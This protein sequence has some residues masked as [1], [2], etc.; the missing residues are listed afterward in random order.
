MSA[1]NLSECGGGQSSVTLF[2]AVSVAYTKTV[3]AWVEVN[4]TTATITLAGPADVWFGFGLNASE[5][6]A[7]PY[8]IIVDGQGNVTERVLAD[9]AA[10]TVLPPLL[11]VL[12]HTVNQG[13]RVLV[14]SRALAGLSA[15][16]F[17]FDS[18]A[19]NSE[20]PVISA[21]GSGPAFALVDRRIKG[22]KALLLLAVVVAG[23]WITCLTTSFDKC[24]CQRVLAWSARNVQRPVFAA[25]C[26]VTTVA[27]I[28]PM[29][30][31]FEVG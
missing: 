15:E 26:V 7:E 27:A 12:S 29:L 3:G 13:R 6:K 30:H 20:L 19:H 16:H 8:A 14:L 25:P 18:L 23:D 21:Y 11:T 5:M 2:G 31:P 17:S 9:Q 4:A 1:V 10:G 24:A 28:V 22:A